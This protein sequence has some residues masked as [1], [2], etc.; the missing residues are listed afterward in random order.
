M[1]FRR[2]F[3]GWSKP[4]TLEFSRQLLEEAEGDSMDNWLVW[5]PSGRAARHILSELF[6]GEEEGTEAFH[7]PHIL[8]PVQFERSLP[9]LEG[10]A[11][12]ARQL[13]AWKTVLT[14]ARPAALEPVFPVVP[15]RQKR[16]WAFSLAEQ[17]MQLRSRLL[18]GGYDFAGVATS[19]L[20]SDQERWKV[21][22]GLEKAYMEELSRSGLPDPDAGYFSR[23]QQ[24]LNLMS[25][26]RLLIGG[27][28]NLSK[29][30]VDC[31]ES[32]AKAGLQVD[33]YFPLPEEE[34]DSL[35]AWGRPK[36]DPWQSRS[37]PEDG[38]SGVL[39]RSAEPRELV[40][41]V[42]ELAE[43]YSTEVDALVL[44]APD[45]EVGKYLV[46]RSRL[47]KTP[48]YMPE[49]K[50]LS[51]TSWGRLL[52][53][54]SQLSGEARLQ[55]HL[56]L[57]RHSLVR[58]WVRERGCPVGKVEEAYLFLMK[59]HLLTHAS[60]LLDPV[61][62]PIHEIGIVRDFLNFLDNLLTGEEEATSFPDWLWRILQEVASGSKLS[63]E[64]RSV[65]GHLEEIL[66]DLQSD[67]EGDDLPEG[68]YW[69]V[70]SHLLETHHYYPEREAEERPVSGWLELPWERSPHLVVLGLPDSK[71]PGSD[72]T[73][74]FLTPALCRRLGLYGPEEA[75]AFHNCRL[76]LLLENR[77]EW[78][79]LDILLPDR[80]LDDDPEQ[81]SRFLFLAEEEEILERVELLMSDGGSTESA[82]PATFGARLQLP[83]PAELEKISVT[84]FSA[85]LY[86][87]LHYFMERSLRW[88]IPRELPVEMD[89]L[90]FGS[91]AH[92][93]VERLNGTDEGVGLLGRADI[94]AF[95]D[96]QLSTI[97]GEEFGRQLGVPAII[98]ESG[99]RE[100]LRAAAGIISEQ[101]Q[102]GW[103]PV[104]AE[105]RF[106]GEVD[107]KI[108]GVRLSG[109]I[110]LVEQNE[111]SGLYRV[112]DY[113][114]SDNAT[115]ARAAHLTRLNASSPD[116]VLPGS[117][118]LDNDKTWRWKDLQLVLYYHAVRTAFEK[119][120]CVAYLNLAKAVKEV[121][122]S[123]WT[124][125]EV[126]AD[127]GLECAR[128]IVRRIK[129]GHFPPGRS[130]RYKEDWL[131]WFGGD[132][133]TGLAEEWQSRHVEGGA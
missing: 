4:F 45:A 3:L 97:M 121:R 16:Q 22:A 111:Q 39:Q 94:E 35:D 1:E 50:S 74:A 68:D 89:A 57:L 36:P 5:V 58:N 17:L 88:S 71:V 63:E 33:F 40:E 78:G 105:W 75:A 125:N 107:F 96:D 48:A 12:E 56:E 61:L 117:D 83:H 31:I 108:E 113:K 133:A 18:Q 126:E 98:Q 52:K 95:L 72:G 55:T 43:V 15:E 8:T 10:C 127:S 84:D 44:G 38:L 6:S 103:K 7:P 28:L 86:S 100:R 123:E 130:I 53:L 62:K 49:G 64:A 102:A 128:E 106:A 76:R 20:E 112:V 70:L 67:L 120:P 119:A 122:L 87:P 66:Q 13:L 132:Y 131:P 77:K 80:G 129:A 85:Y 42:L 19:S 60:Q 90:H 11:S 29:R 116:P 73:D 91:L 14:Q 26:K 82:I 104:K 109:I 37:L 9:G 23:L 115:E 114:T 24:A 124:I 92:T 99:L 2:H 25:W 69:E 34:A 21:L 93:V 110:D 81:P 51:E 47:T 59:E 118:F 65:L 46:E 79:K 54:I 41:K 27:V 101:R 32:L 30:Q